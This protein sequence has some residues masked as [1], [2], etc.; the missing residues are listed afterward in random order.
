MK[1]FLSGPFAFPILHHEYRGMRAAVPELMAFK[2]QC[3]HNFA[4]FSKEDEG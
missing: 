2:Q 4:N 1:N 3:G